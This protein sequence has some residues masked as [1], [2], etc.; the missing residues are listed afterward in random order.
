MRRAVGHGR[1][2]VAGYA[3]WRAGGARRRLRRAARA[4]R[5]VND[6]RAMTT[7]A[8]RYL[9]RS[10]FIPFAYL[11]VPSMRLIFS[12]LDS[13]GPYWYEYRSS[14]H[15]NKFACT[16]FK[17]N[18]STTELI[19]YKYCFL[20]YLLEIRDFWMYLKVTMFSW[21]ILLTLPTD[22]RSS[23]LGVLKQFRNSIG[24]FLYWKPTRDELRYDLV[25]VW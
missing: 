18:N 21:H 8:R 5:G 14:L 22:F 17:I 1:C 7:R 10:S 16:Y 12:T 23:D 2:R 25:L 6:Y 19:L 9:R 11:R 24:S 20:I 4:P 13:I 15:L 3:K